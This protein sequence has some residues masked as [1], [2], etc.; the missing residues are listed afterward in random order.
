MNEN[1]NEKGEYWKEL[2]KFI[3]KEVVVE[4]YLNNG[5]LLKTE[6]VLKGVNFQH[7]SCIIMTNEEKII[8]KLFHRIIRKR[9]YNIKE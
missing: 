1:I 3:N 8:I 6:G 2:M 4:T 5:K 9:D 7:L